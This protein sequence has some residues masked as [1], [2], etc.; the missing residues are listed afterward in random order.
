MREINHLRLLTVGVEVTRL[1]PFRRRASAVT[2]SAQRFFPFRPRALRHKPRAFLK[3]I[4]HNATQSDVFR[5]LG[6]KT[7]T[8]IE[9]A[10]QTTEEPRASVLDCGG[11]LPLL[12]LMAVHR[13]LRPAQPMP[14]KFPGPLGDFTRLYPILPAPNPFFGSPK[15]A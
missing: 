5:R 2:E 8:C 10:V 15:I 9:K 11:P 6:W 7:T 12:E 1:C 3:I 14:Q 13:N 4:R